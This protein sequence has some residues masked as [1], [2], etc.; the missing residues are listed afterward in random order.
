MT[1][2]ARGRSQSSVQHGAPQSYQTVKPGISTTNRLSSG[3]GSKLELPAP[4]MSGSGVLDY[5]LARP[6][7]ATSFLHGQ[8]IMS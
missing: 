3:T 2:Y 7:L 4:G 8:A 6:C 1:F 5:R